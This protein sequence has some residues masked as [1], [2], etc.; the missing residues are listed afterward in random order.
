MVSRS[1]ISALSRSIEKLAEAF[2]PEVELPSC[3]P[4]ILAFSQAHEN[5]FEERQAYMAHVDRAAVRKEPLRYEVDMVFRSV[6]S[7]APVPSVE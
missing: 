1:Q 2:K 6:G 3:V 7:S 5:T 4:I